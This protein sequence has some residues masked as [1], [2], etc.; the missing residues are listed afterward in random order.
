MKN[1]LGISLQHT[2]KLL[3]SNFAKRLLYTSCSILCTLVFFSCTTEFDPEINEQPMTVLNVL[4]QNDS[5]ITAQVSRSWI[6]NKSDEFVKTG[7]YDSPDYFVL[8][9]DVA[10]RDAKVECSVN[11][12]EWVQMTYNPETYNYISDMKAKEGDR[13]R[14]RAFSSYGKAEG[15]TEIPRLIHIEKVEHNIRA[16]VDS[17]SMMFNPDGTI[18]HPVAFDV[19]YY[20]TFTDPDW[21]DRYYMVAGDGYVDDPIIGENESPMDAVLNKYHYCSFFSNA[22]IKAQK[23]TLSLFTNHYYFPG[24]GFSGAIGLGKDPNTIME[25]IKLY[26]I[27]KDYYLYVLSIFKKYTGLQG[28]LENFGV[29]DPRSVYSNITPPGIGIVAGSSLSDYSINIAPDLKKA[30]EEVQ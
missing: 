5:I 27:S 17:Q 11:N 28:I 16:F 20:V 18:T 2:H 1:I 7:V 21:E 29:A 3:P 25:T 10:I 26:S 6:F 22:T 23:Y 4:A 19:H 15:Y 8:P 24:L 14:V 12:G 30:L 9:Q 13:I